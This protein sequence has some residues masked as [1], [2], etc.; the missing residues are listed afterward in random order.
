MG[1]LHITTT[2]TLHAVALTMDM[3][4]DIVL[5]YHI[6]TLRIEADVMYINDTISIR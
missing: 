5:S 4:H 3:D 1:A 6:I 2:A